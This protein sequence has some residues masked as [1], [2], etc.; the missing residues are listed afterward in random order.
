MQWRSISGNSIVK[1]TAAWLG[2]TTSAVAGV[3]VV[4]ASPALAAS[5]AEAYCWWNLSDTCGYARFISE[6]GDGT[7]KLVIEDDFADGW[8]VAVENYRYDLA[9]TGPYY[10]MNRKGAY[11]TTTYVLHIP[12][13]KR[14]AFRVCPEKDGIAYLDY[15]GVWANGYA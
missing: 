15:C 2:V 6:V 10:G 4:A 11:T 9:N 13:G 12:E 8:G 1:R 14:I 5:D 7:E 3:L